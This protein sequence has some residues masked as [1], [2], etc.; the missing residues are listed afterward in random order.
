MK[1]GAT[2][3]LQPVFLVKRYTC[4]ITIDLQEYMVHHSSLDVQQDYTHRRKRSRWC[5]RPPSRRKWHKLNPPMALPYPAWANSLSVYKVQ[6]RNLGNVWVERTRS[7]QSFSKRSIMISNVSQDT[8]SACSFLRS[9][10]TPSSHSISI[11]NPGEQESRSP[12]PGPT[13][14]IHIVF[15]LYSKFPLQWL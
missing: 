15:N 9:A 1:R 10:F 11:Q 8:R 14:L 5:S 12:S 13:L 2:L 4:G 7:N 3:D 6:V